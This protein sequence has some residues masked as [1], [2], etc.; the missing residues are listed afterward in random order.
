MG[1]YSSLTMVELSSLAET[2]AG[3]RQYFVDNARRFIDELE[4]IKADCR[5]ADFEC[6]GAFDNGVEDL[7]SELRERFCE[8]LKGELART[9]VESVGVLIRDLQSCFECECDDDGEAT[10]VEG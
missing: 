2:D 10:D 1:N 3:A 4:E 7:R 8:T 9:R 6:E 5:R